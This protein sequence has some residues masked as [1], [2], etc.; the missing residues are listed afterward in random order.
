M[1]TDFYDTFSDSQL[2]ETLDIVIFRP[3]KSTIVVRVQDKHHDS[4][5]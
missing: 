5:L 3:T 1:K 4:I 2:R